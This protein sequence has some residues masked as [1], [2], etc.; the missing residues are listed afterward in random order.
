LKGARANLKN[1]GHVISTK[2][3]S[4]GVFRK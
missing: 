2:Y 3:Q 4:S 1:C